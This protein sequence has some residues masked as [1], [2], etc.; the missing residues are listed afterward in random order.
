MYR[1]RTPLH[2]HKTLEF[3]AKKRKKNKGTVLIW[4][5]YLKKCKGEWERGERRPEYV[6]FVWIKRIQTN[7][8][9]KLGNFI[10]MPCRLHKI[11]VEK[12]KYFFT[13]LLLF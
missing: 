3:S 4:Y 7:D 5:R 13:V 6:A 12:K 9:Y 8:K 11:S 1:F 10:N 2:K